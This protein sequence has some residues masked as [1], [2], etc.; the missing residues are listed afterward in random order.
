MVVLLISKCK[1]GHELRHH[2]KMNTGFRVCV[3]EKDDND[4]DP[5]L[6]TN[7]VDDATC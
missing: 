6:C 4:T 1:C 7:Y 5:C 3:Y 2:W